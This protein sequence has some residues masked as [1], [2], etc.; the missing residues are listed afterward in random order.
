[1][2]VVWLAMG[3]VL[4]ARAWPDASARGRRALLGLGLGLFLAWLPDQYALAFLFAAP[5]SLGDY[6]YVAGE[7]IVLVSLSVWI[8]GGRRL[9]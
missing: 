7:L 3:G 5:P 9:R 6:K 2:N 8:R 1:M 4:L